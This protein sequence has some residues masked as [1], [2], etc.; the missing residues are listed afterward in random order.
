MGAGKDFVCR[1][2]RRRKLRRPHV[3]PNRQFNFFSVVTEKVCSRCGVKKSGSM[4]G[5][6]AKTL[7]GLSYWCNQCGSEYQQR[8]YYSNLEVNRQRKREWMAK[9]REDPEKRRE[10][11]ERNRATYFLRKQ[12]TRESQREMWQ[13]R[14][15]WARAQKI[16]SVRLGPE[17]AKLW[18]KQRG[19]CAL[20]GIRLNRENAHLDHILPKARGG[21]NDISNLRWTCN[22]VNR[23]KHDL[24]D[25]EFFRICELVLSRSER[26]QEV[27]KIPCR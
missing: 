12:R 24:T 18:H 9:Q 27:D 10:I 15:F 20:T 21:T 13:R 26:L 11:N 25:E 14:F 23:A 16:G 3:D 4:F 2:H 5:A 17:L 7:D 19:C 22:T 6:R 1:W 8:H